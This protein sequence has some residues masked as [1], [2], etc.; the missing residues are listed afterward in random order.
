[1]LIIFYHIPDTSK[2]K[3]HLSIFKKNEIF[4]PLDSSSIEVLVI[5]LSKRKTNFVHGFKAGFETH[6]KATKTY[7]QSSQKK[8]N[9]CPVM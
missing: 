8:N 6:P 2:E 5:K 4:L 7:V 9:L 1:M 3:R